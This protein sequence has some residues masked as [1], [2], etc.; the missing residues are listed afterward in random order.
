MKGWNSL[1]FILFYFI[2]WSLQETSVQTYYPVMEKSANVLMS[3]II[4]YNLVLNIVLVVPRRMISAVLLSCMVL[5]KHFEAEQVMS[6]Q[7]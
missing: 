4:I 5:L 3:Y 2:F 7:N 1:D 6:W